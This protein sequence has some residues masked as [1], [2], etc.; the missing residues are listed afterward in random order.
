M[1]LIKE[2]IRKH[3][4]RLK[5][6][7]VAIKNSVV[8][9]II[10][11]VEKR[12]IRDTDGGYVDNLWTQEDWDDTAS[13]FEGYESE[14]ESDLS[15]ESDS[16]AWD[17]DIP[18]DEDDNDNGGD[19]G[20]DGGD[21]DGGDDSGGDDDGNG[22]TGEGGDGGDDNG[23]PDDHSKSASDPMDWSPEPQPQPPQQPQPAKF[24][25]LQPSFLQAFSDL[26]LPSPTQAPFFWP[27]RPPPDSDGEEEL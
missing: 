26:A 19:G 21:D 20:E 14:L 23:S 1:H 24:P 2:V 10:R 3:M 13:E 25:D 8:Q 22:S 11:W 27:P 17:D 7:K 12:T 6:L 18:D 9:R 5:V 16:E 4:P 15:E